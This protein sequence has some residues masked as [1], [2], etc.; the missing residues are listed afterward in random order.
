VSRAATARDAAGI[1]TVSGDS[2]MDGDAAGHCV[3]VGTGR[4][5]TMS[6]GGGLEARASSTPPPVPR[7]RPPPPPPPQVATDPSPAVDDALDVASVYDQ[8][9][10]FVFRSLRRLGVPDRSVDD[11]VQDVFIVVHRRLGEFEARSSLRS[12]LFGIARR[13]A[14]DHRRRIGRK[15]RGEELPETLIDPAGS[16]PAV[17]VERA[18]AVQV[19]H[20]ILAS[21]D[22]EKR[23]VFMLAELEQMTVPEIAA[24]IGVNLNTVYSRLRAARIAFDQA[25]ARHHARQRGGER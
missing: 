19:L 4:T 20:A 11:A 2:S 8:H 18:Q 1:S 15:E 3:D 16:T 5:M 21:L 10:A 22:D 12:W 17:D 9:A 6:L 24:A 14:H 25:V 7:R 13:V 23:E